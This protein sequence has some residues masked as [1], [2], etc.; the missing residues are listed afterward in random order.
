[1]GD[2]RAKA[3]IVSH[4]PR[5]GSSMGKIVLKGDFSHLVYIRIKLLL[6][7]P[8]WHVIRMFLSFFMRIIFYVY[9][10]NLIKNLTCQHNCIFFLMR[11]SYF[12]TSSSNLQFLQC[13]CQPAIGQCWAEGLRCKRAAFSVH[14]ARLVPYCAPKTGRWVCSSGANTTW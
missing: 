4:H 7:V 11:R 12:L 3:T 2:S 8:I 13:F 1:M 14:V 6:F 9:Y 5:S 10:A